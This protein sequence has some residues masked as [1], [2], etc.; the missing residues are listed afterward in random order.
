M[1][2]GAN[3]VWLCCFSKGG[4]AEQD[5]VTLLTNQLNPP[6]EPSSGPPIAL[7]PGKGISYMWQ[8]PYVNPALL[9]QEQQSSMAKAKP[10]PK[11]RQT[12]G[13]KAKAKTKAKP[14]AKPRSKAMATPKSKAKAKAKPKSKTK[15]KG[16]SA[17]KEEAVWKI[18]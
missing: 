9:Q 5:V 15:T 14:K 2:V 13:P 18:W 7:G 10:K 6:G 17:K 16:R 11:Q 4:V 12:Q 1:S 8:D 3:K